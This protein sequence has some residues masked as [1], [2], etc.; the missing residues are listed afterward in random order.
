METAQHPRPALTGDAAPFWQLL[1]DGTLHVQACG[2]C[3][4]LRHPPRPRCAHCHS[5]RVRWEPVSGRAEVWSFTVCH[6]PVLPAFAARVPYVAAVVRLVE[7]PFMVTDLVDVA[8]DEAVV[9]MAVEVV[10]EPLDDEVS[11]PRFRRA[12][13]A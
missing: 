9:G 13:A 12:D 11:L 5:D 6:P 1:R 8:P 10:I 3:G 7:G 4:A 2:E